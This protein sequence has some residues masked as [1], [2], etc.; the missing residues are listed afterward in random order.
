MESK[1]AQPKTQ[2]PMNPPFIQYVKANSALIECYDKV[3]PE[4][5]KKLT[6]TAQANLCLSHKLKIREIL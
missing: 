2:D 4:D 6:S 1:S 5:Y 3:K